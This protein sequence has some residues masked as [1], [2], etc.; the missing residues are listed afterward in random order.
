[1]GLPSSGKSMLFQALTG[2]RATGDVGM[3]AIP[4]ER[5]RPV[6]EVVRPRPGVVLPAGQ[7]EQHEDGAGDRGPGAVVAGGAAHHR[8]A[9]A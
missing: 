7:R 6:A 3:A 4:D 2:S 1:M 8:R 5:L 9:D